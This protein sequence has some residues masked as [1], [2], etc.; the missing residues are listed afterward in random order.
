M[1]TQ[2]RNAVST[3]K[4]GVDRIIALVGTLILIST[5][6][7]G[8]SDNGTDA[9]SSAVPTKDTAPITE[10]VEAPAKSAPAEQATVTEEVTTQT[11]PVEEIA[12]ETAP[13]AAPVANPV[14]Q[15]E[16]IYKSGCFACHA[17][18]VAGAP[19]FGNAALWKERIAKGKDS[20]VNNA[21]K[22]FTGSTGVMPPK[23]GFAHFSDE[24]IAAAVNYM[25]EAAQ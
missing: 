7:F 6:M 22:G 4:M 25:I 21:I 24:E 9:K 14:S 11:P 15:G 13:P 16:N 10:S 2:N 19:T 12:K 20:L 3:R 5:G 17:T 18:G 8:C 1:T 23:G